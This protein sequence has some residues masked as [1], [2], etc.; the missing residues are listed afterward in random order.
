[1]TM[2]IMDAPL[3]ELSRDGDQADPLLFPMLVGGE[4]LDPAILEASIDANE[5]L[6]RFGR[7]AVDE[8]LAS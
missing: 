4:G 6:K 2:T 5:H 3:Y 8:L 7:P 1:M